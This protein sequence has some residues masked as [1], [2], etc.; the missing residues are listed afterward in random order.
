MV[1]NGFKLGCL[2]CTRA[3]WRDFAQIEFDF[4]KI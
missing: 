1:V 4:N 3:M 2:K